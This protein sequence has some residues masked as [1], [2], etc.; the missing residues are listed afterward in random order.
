M[1]VWIIRNENPYGMLLMFESDSLALKFLNEKYPDVDPWMHT[2]KPEQ[3]M[4]MRPIE[5][6]R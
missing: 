4:L 5:N 1:E 3:Y 6:R 2:N